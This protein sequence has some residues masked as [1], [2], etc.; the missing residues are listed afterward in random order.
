MTSRTLVALISATVLSACGGS[1]N[2]SAGIDGGGSPGLVATTI[3]SQ[4][5]ITGFGSVIVNGVRFETTNATFIIDGQ[6]GSQDDLSVG[7][8]VLV[9]GTIEDGGTDGTADSISFDDNVEG[10]ISSIDRVAGTLV[11][12]GQLVTITAATSFDDS[13]QPASLD[14]LNPS[15]IVEVTGF[16]DATGV[17][18]ATRLELK[19]GGDQFELTGIVSTL[20]VEDS[21]FNINSLIVDFSSANLVNF[22]SGSI[23]DG[24]VVEVKGDTFDGPDE[25]IATQV[26]LKSSP[27]GGSSI[28]RLEIEGFITRF[29]SASDFD[30]SGLPVVTTDQTLFEG[31][32]AADL[33]L[34]IKVEVEGDLDAN[35]VLVASSVD[36]RRARVVRAMALVDSVNAGGNA[37][38]TLGITVNVDSLTRVE[39]KSDQSVRPFGLTQLVA[40]D[41]VEVRGTEFPAGSGEI[42]AGRLERRNARPET[43]LQGFVVDFSEPA[44]AILGVSIETDSGVIFSDENDALLSAPDFFGRLTQG[45]LVKAKGIEVAAQILDADEVEFEAE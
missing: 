41:Y 23:S 44:I 24:D 36:I 29:A 4:G 17:I 16:V 27:L 31:G 14:G 20:S 19:S 10:P 39:D 33:G 38:V 1:G 2:L 32:V 42:L 45:A 6:S 8:V 30:V 43:I 15:D 11:V 40:G 9:Q 12:L 21:Q 18:S 7:D 22:P 13:I 25:F 37:F 35:N 3:I 34:N 26:E 28:D 5:T